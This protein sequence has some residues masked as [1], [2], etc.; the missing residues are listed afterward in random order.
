LNAKYTLECEG[1]SFRIEQPS[2]D[3]ICPKC[4][5]SLE[6]IYDYE[7][8]RETFTKEQLG[9]RPAS[10]WKYVEILP[11]QHLANIVT[12]GE[13]GT[14]LLNADRL[15]NELGLNRLFLKDESRNPTGSFKDR[16]STVA[17]TK[18]RE[19]DVETVVSATAGNAGASVAAYA[20][21]AG[22]R[23]VI[24]AFSNITRTKLA[25]L[26]SYGPDVFVVE[27]TSWDAI[28]FTALVC[29]HYGWYSIV[30]A[31]KYN[32]Y[33]KDGAKTEAIEICEQLDWTA[34]DWLIVPVGGGCGLASCWKG[35]KELKRLGMIDSLPRIVGVQG[36]QCAPLVKAFDNNV[37]A[38]RIQR[39]PDAHTVA[40]SIE[41]DYPPDG[42]QALVAIRESGG[43]A[44]G[45][46]DEEILAAQR[47]IGKKEGLFLEP[48]SSAP[49]VAAKKL[50]DQ[51]T[52]D[53]S[54]VVVTVATGLGLNEPDAIFS[55][56]GTPQTIKP[57]IHDFSI[58]MRRLHPSRADT[59]GLDSG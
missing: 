6:T 13:G 48:A 43:L 22:L 57:T 12:I 17:L 52:I 19:F 38:D 50:L 33:V 24:F 5:G 23:A 58:A 37:P 54:D 3:S 36:A 31:S 34:P 2:K 9:G 41:D 27:G 56:Y 30:A 14:R 39:V 25:K 1:C 10:V 18:A 21:R 51:G 44:L 15:G 8:V 26:V 49:V 20:A 53:P 47:L 4:G 32:P 11:V 29:K 35:V 55:S 59:A 45:I 40:H 16:K 28:E 42:K 7:T 46:R